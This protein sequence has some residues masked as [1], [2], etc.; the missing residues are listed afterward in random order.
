[1]SAVTELIGSA[2]SMPG[3]RAIKL[4]QSARSAPTSVTAGISVR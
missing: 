3:M 1:M 4:Q 2:P